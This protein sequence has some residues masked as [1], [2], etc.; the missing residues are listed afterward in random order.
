VVGALDATGTHS[1]ALP[2]ATKSGLPPHGIYDLV[3]CGLRGVAIEV[4][5]FHSAARALGA[6]QQCCLARIVVVIRRQYLVSGLTL[7]PEYRRASPIDVLSVRAM[8]ALL[9]PK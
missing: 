8:S 4:D 6:D 7:R 3:R 1:E 2:Y 9:T 5:S